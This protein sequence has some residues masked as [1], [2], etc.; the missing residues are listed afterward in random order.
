MN[1]FRFKVGKR[2]IYAMLVIL[3]LTACGSLAPNPHAHQGQA[4]ALEA[5]EENETDPNTAEE[6]VPSS[7]DETG[8]AVQ[9]G[10]PPAEAEPYT[11]SGR[12]LAVGD[13]MMHSP[14]F[15]AYLNPK[16]GKYDFRGFFTNVKPMLQEADW[17]WAN[18][19]TPLLGGEK[20]YTGYPMFNAPPEL[21]DALKDAGFNIVTAANN[22][23]LDRWERGALR[24]REVLKDRGLV[25]KGISAS[26]WESKQPTLM[27]KN[28]ISMGILAYTYGT[29]ESRFPR[30]SRTSSL[31]LTKSA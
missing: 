29:N 27:E 20:V 7:T 6:A 2:F 24:T 3:L 16:T 4:A 30:I 12:L 1:K 8:A 21:A 11:L 10:E 19:E 9:A 22:H 31:S 23:T 26:L 15:P 13:I 5:G 14:Q 28:G 18:L 25:T 17:C